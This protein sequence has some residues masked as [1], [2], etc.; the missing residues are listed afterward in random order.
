LNTFVALTRGRLFACGK[1]KSFNAMKATNR[2]E[3]GVECEG[4]DSTHQR[5][6][7]EAEPDSH[8]LL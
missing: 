2:G 7:T 1:V 5:H 8:Q 6:S 3:A 4:L